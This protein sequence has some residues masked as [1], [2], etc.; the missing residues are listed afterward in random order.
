MYETKC[1]LVRSEF[2]F[3]NLQKTGHVS[4]FVGKDMIFLKS[5][6]F[7]ASVAGTA[8]ALRMLITTTNS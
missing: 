7:L 5:D 6:P 8:L 3:K 1:E 4:Q 2:D